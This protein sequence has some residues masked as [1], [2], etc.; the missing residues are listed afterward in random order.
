[1][2]CVRLRSAVRPTISTFLGIAAALTLLS[3]ASVSRARDEP[4][5]GGA[6]V[7]RRLQPTQYQNIISDVFGRDVIAS[8]NF[9]PPVR[10]DGL[11]ALGATSASI[12]ATGFKQYD[13]MAQA[14]AKQVVDE[15]HRAAL[16]PCT[17]ASPKMRD[18]KCAAIFLESVGTLLF[19]RP[20]SAAQLGGYVKVA[21]DSADKLQDFYKGLERSLNL[22]LISPDF[23]FV[24]DVVEPDRKSRGQYRIDNYSLASRLSFLFWNTSPDNQ[25]LLAASKGQLQ[26]PR[27]LAREVDRLV[28][29]PRLADGVRAFFSDMY[30]FE[31]FETLAKDTS[32]YPKFAAKLV[33]DAKE[34]TLRTI[35]DHVVVRNADYRDLFTTRRTFLTPQLAA[36]YQVTVNPNPANDFANGVPAQWVPYEYPE[37][38]PRVGLFTQAGFAALHSH[39][40]RSSPTLRGKAI[41][42]LFLCQKVPPPPPNV[43][44]AVVQDTNNPVHRTA[45]DRV[46]AHL[47]SPVC[48]GCH[49]ITDP[50]GLALENFDSDGAF[51]TKENQVDIDTSGELNG[52]R[53]AD[54]AGLAQAIHD[55]P[56]LT[57]CVVSRLY[58]FAVGKAADAKETGT[59]RQ[60]QASFAER[61]Y[62]LPELMRSIALSEAFQRAPGVMTGI[63]MAEK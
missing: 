5:A 45:R 46:Q 14:V 50:I 12:T 55:S 13:A 29:S 48:A 11:L 38:D 16:I 23:L 37:G 15:Q 53:F 58:S 4:S 47:G 52:V 9:E 63:E 31:E 54:A 59:L 44:F 62:R 1:M 17:P 42:E 49:K 61:G 10:Q 27:G 34:Q 22:M 28:S 2:V 39:P 3:S 19:R 56:A 35:I 40:G 30:G 24:K 21:A 7:V 41:R 43:D 57:S 60:F 8:G 25:L 6:A 51:R 33:E 36:L 32:I 26:T 18:D 20:L